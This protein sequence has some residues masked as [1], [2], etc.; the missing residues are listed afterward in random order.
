M[1]ALSQASLKQT[2]SFGKVLH[3]N[4]IKHFV[5]VLVG[6]YRQLEV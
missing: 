5:Q 6:H 3:H 1:L 4:V 2:A